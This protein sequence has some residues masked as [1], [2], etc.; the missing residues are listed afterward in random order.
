MVDPLS[1]MLLILLLPAVATAQDDPAQDD[2]ADPPVAEAVTEATASTDGPRRRRYTA[3]NAG[4]ERVSDTFGNTLSAQ[5]G[6]LDVHFGTQINDTI[7]VYVPLHLAFGPNGLPARSTT[8]FLSH[9]GRGGTADQ[10]RRMRKAGPWP[11]LLLEARPRR[12]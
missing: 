11:R 7:G 8:N 2:P 4:L 10:R 5:M 6:G 12:S 9:L 3:L 1:S